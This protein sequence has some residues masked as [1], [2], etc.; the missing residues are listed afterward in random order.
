MPQDL[1]LQPFLLPSSRHEHQ[2]H[3][4]CFL[5][6]IH[7]QHCRRRDCRLCRSE[8]PGAVLGRALPMAAHSLSNVQ[9]GPC[10]PATQHQRHPP[11][12]ETHLLPGL[13]RTLHHRVGTETC[14]ATFR[15]VCCTTCKHTE[16]GVVCACCER[17]YFSWP[18][19]TA[20]G[21]LHQTFQ[22]DA[23]ISCLT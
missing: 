5:V 22:K 18:C 1:S 13:R 6:T 19:L 16:K 3:H 12:T 2:E 9:N 4:S 21:S 15:A 17:Q 14:S 7:G 20:A 8:N 11:G 23:H 10:W